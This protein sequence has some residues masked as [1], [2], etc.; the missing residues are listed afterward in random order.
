MTDDLS[1]ASEQLHRGLVP[2][3]WQRVSYPSLKPLASYIADLNIRMQ[4]L[5]KWATCQRAPEVFWLSGFFFT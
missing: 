2:D 5:Q 1:L 3:I 4:M